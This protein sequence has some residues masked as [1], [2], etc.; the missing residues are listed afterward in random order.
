ME[1]NQIQAQMSDYKNTEEY[2]K[3]QSVFKE[4]LGLSQD[5]II[6]QDIIEKGID[7]SVQNENNK[8]NFTKYNIISLE[9]LQN[10]LF[11][12]LNNTT[13]PS[14]NSIKK[15]CFLEQIIY[16]FWNTKSLDDRINMIKLF[17]TL[18]TPKEMEFIITWRLP[19]HSIFQV[20]LTMDV[21]E[22]NAFA[23]LKELEKF[24]S[25]D[26][27]VTTLE[28]IDDGIFSG[29]LKMF[30][31]NAMEEN[32]L[33][34]L[35]RLRIFVTEKKW[36]DIFSNQNIIKMF[37]N[38]FDDAIYK[39][40]E[41]NNNDEDNDE[42]EEQIEKDNWRQITAKIIE[43]Y[44]IAQTCNFYYNEIEKKNMFHVF[45]KM[46]DFSILNALQHDDKRINIKDIYDNGNVFLPMAQKCKMVK[47]LYLKY[48]S[49][50][51]LVRNSNFLLYSYIRNDLWKEI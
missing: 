18:C 15:E 2:K 38:S 42:F 25:R 40:Y 41:L 43:N 47:P 7:D 20:L 51:K 34:A 22:K 24:Y 17:S 45:M 26:F 12:Q 27:I 50:K 23:S 9:E 37:Y 14:I 32:G 36:N 46:E 33:N 8:Q 11:M 13:N 30:I 29:Y 16:C 44:L 31:T 1:Q 3:A 39:E 28:R 10:K 19:R 5:D 35:E 48:I 6:T 4:C 49:Y 21:R